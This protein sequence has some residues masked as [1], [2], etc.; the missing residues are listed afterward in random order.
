MILLLVLAILGAGF[1]FRRG[2]MGL[3]DSGAAALICFGVAVSVRPE[4]L[5][6]AGALTPTGRAVAWPLILGAILWWI[7]HSSAAAVPARSTAA[8]YGPELA[9]VLVFVAL[10][11]I[12]AVLSAPNSYDGLTYHLPRLERGI[13]QGPLQPYAAHD[14]RQP[15]M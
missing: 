10:T 5:P 9:I 3:L 11:G 14:P 7:R 4:W 12:V 1:A 6:R 2:G 13:A 15:T 8:G